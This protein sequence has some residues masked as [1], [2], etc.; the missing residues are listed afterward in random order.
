MDRQPIALKG[1]HQGG[2]LGVN[3]RDDGGEGNGQESKGGD[4]NPDDLLPVFEFEN[5]VDQNNGPGE[6]DQGFIHIG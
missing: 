4:K 5:Q 3:A 2:D 6:E 1:G